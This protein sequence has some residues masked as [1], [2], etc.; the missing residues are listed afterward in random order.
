M[1]FIPADE[2]EDGKMEHLDW[3]GNKDILITG[4]ADFT[5]RSWSFETGKTIKVCYDLVLTILSQV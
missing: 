1:I 4:S 3:D 2:E 5:A